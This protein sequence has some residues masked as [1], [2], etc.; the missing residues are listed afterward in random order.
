MISEGDT[1]ATMSG[2]ANISPQVLLMCNKGI[3]TQNLQVGQVI[4][5]PLCTASKK[6][7]VQQGDTLQSVAE[8]SK[9]DLGGMIDCNAKLPRPEFLVPGEVIQIP[10]DPKASPNVPF[11]DA[12]RP[13]SYLSW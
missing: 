9:V 5:Y 4:K 10:V 8:K 11:D 1:F 12:L 3:D 6:Y 13:S 7:K 2:K